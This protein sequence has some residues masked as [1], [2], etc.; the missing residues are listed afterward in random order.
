MKNMVG[1]LCHWFTQLLDRTGV[2]F[3]DLVALTIALTYGGGLWLHLAHKADGATEVNEPPALIHWLRDSTLM[4]PLVLVSVFAALLFARWFRQRLGQ[5]APR[6]VEHAAVVGSIALFTSVA[7]AMASPIH[8]TLFHAHHP[9]HHHLD[10][11]EALLALQQSEEETPLIF[12][13]DAETLLALQQDDAE[14]P[15]ALQHSDAEIPLTLHMLHDGM[16]ALIGNL[17]LSSILVAL[18]RGRLWGK[19]PARRIRAIKPAR[20]AQLAHR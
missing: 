14:T 11:T 19:H 17:A 10:D 6:V 20:P 4:L 7:L 16:L 15:L 1:S 13:D 5:G 8:N 9:A 2:K 18:F 3:S 12:Q